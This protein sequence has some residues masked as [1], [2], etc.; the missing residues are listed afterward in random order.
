MQ[1]LS[2]VCQALRNRSV[3]DF[4][5]KSLHTSYRHH[6]KDRAAEAISLVDESLNRLVLSQKEGVNIRAVAEAGRYC[7]EKI[8]QIHTE[9]RW[10]G[11]MYFTYRSEQKVKHDYSTIKRYLS[12]GS[13]LDFGSGDG[14]FTHYLTNQGYLV[15]GTDVRDYRAPRTTDFHFSVM[16][17]P[18]TLGKIP[19]QF[20]TVIVKSVMHHIED[21][22]L[23]E[24]L[25]L[26]RERT[27][28]RLIMKEDICLLD[29]ESFPQGSHQDGD[30]V[31][32]YIELGVNDQRQYLTLMDFFGNFVAQG[33]FFLNLPFNFKS[34]HQWESVLRNN[35]FILEKTIPELFDLNMV[36]PGPHMWMIYSIKPK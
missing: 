35:G 21:R 30:I 7:N 1:N 11:D 2:L 32:Q 29:A 22:Y 4:I 12:Q 18:D 28:L 8:M 10:F 25:R 17:S 23:D 36:H 31:S 13:V 24:D 9:N 16:R 6:F 15:W 27:I 3:V 14:Y 19:S 26:L 34:A 5:T 33:L 20:N